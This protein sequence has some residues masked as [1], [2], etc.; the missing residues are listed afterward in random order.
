MNIFFDFDGTLIDSKL[1]QYELF[2][3]LVPES[4]F[5]YEEYWDIKRNRINQ[6][7]LLVD[8]FSYKSDQLS[9]IKKTWMDEIEHPDNIEKDTPF[10]GVGQLLSQLSKKC[11]LY[12]VTARQ[13]TDVV[14]HQVDKFGWSSFFKKLL[15]TNQTHTKVEL[16]RENVSCNSTDIFIGDTGEDIKTGKLLGIKTIAVTYGIL[17]NKILSEYNPDY[18][19]D[20]IDGL[21]D[22]INTLLIEIAP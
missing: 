7:K 8:F 22:V 18:L 2:C 1:R 5:S 19:V 9:Y 12:L 13:S 17:S 10:L 11:N 15:V 4:H 6:E 21:K 20:S 3:K 14:K 16:I